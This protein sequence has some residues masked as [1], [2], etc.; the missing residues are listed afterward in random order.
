MRGFRLLLKRRGATTPA[1]RSLQAIWLC[2]P[3]GIDRVV[4]AMLNCLDRDELWL[5]ACFFHGFGAILKFEASGDCCEPGT[6]IPK[7]SY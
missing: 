3:T 2:R 4:I 5:A 6:A 1:G 7:N